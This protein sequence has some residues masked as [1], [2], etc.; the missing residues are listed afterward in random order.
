MEKRDI[1][2]WNEMV[3]AMACACG[4]L[5]SGVRRGEIGAVEATKELRAAIDLADRTAEESARERE[6]A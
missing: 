4:W 3:M 2:A 5:A 1:D 6:A